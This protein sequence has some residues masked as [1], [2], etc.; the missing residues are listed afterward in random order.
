[1]SKLSTVPTSASVNATVLDQ[2]LNP[3]KGEEKDEDFKLDKE[4][5]S[6]PTQELLG[7]QAAV[8]KK[9]KNKKKNSAKHSK[10]VSLSENVGAA[11]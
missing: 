5:V 8:G 6:L 10:K 1:M 3:S 9:K 2:S 11:N 4:D 7:G